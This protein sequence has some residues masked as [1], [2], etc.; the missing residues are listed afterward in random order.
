MT[1]SKTNYGNWIRKKAIVAILCISVLFLA[2]GFIP[3]H[4]LIRIMM[5]IFSGL[6][7]LTALIVALVYWYFSPNGGDYQR[8]I[9]ELVIRKLS[10][11]GEGSCL[12]IGAGNG[13][14][15]IE[16]AKRFPKSTFTGLDYWGKNWEYS[17]HACEQNA[18]LEGVDSR[19]SFENASASKL[20]FE[21]GHFDSAVSNLTF[22]EV[23]DEKNKLLLIQ[24]ALRVVK[25]GGNFSF[26]DLFFDT[27]H[28]GDT[29]G[30][31]DY[32]DSLGLK[33]YSLLKVTESIDLPLILRY[34]K[35]L[36]NAGIIYG[37][38]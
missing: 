4:I 15:I 30:L 6:S 3:W 38:I 32:L 9:F 33:E 27:S 13:F 36:G 2:C 17:K 20:P 16:L 37:T 28:Y 31:K 29:G 24:E 5:F 19:V 14:L 26:L 12:D 25:N 35:V 21:D 7:F 11:N 18:F 8:K 34:R 23:K 22:H 10:W 1:E